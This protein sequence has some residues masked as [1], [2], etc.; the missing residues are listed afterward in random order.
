MFVD[1]FVCI[2]SSIRPVGVFEME[3]FATGSKTVLEAIVAATE[4]GAT[5]IIGILY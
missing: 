5:S 3:K 1:L 4:K 2:H